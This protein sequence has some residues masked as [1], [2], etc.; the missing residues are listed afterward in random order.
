[1]ANARVRAQRSW[2]MPA[3]L[4]ILALA[5]A[6]PVQPTDSTARDRAEIPDA[7]EA[8]ARGEAPAGLER[9]E[10]K[11]PGVLYMRPGRPIGAFDSFKLIQ[12][13]VRF[14]DEQHAA[15][16]AERLREHVLST[17]MADMRAT[18]L[19]IVDKPD[20]CTLLVE[21]GILDIELS[22]PVDASGSNTHYE[23]TWGTA[24][25]V[26]RMYD[27]ETR[28]PLMQFAVRR[29]IP[30]RITSA[31]QHGRDW[32]QIKRTLDRLLRDTQKALLAGLPITAIPPS[33]PGCAGGIYALRRRTG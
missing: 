28:L 24:T 9:V 2:A 17:V 23:R 14:R 26:Q 19:P 22:E 30:G 8:P 11:T 12:L 21:I 4:S 27:G 29:P 20:R 7:S 1:M 33:K 6:T 18:G 15:R 10:I 16:D 31:L 13:A 25:L 32:D 5:C 3:A